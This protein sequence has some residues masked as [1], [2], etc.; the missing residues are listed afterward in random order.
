MKNSLKLTKSV[1]Y[2]KKLIKKY[3]PEFSI[4][5]GGYTSVPLGIASYM[6]GVP[7]FIHEQNSIPSYSNILLS[8]FAKKVFYTFDFSRKY[9]SDKS[10]KVGMPL[11]KKLKSRLSLK[12]EEAREILGISNEDTIILILGG[13]QGARIFGDIT[14]NLSQKMKNIKFILIRGKNVRTNFNENNVITFDYYE[15]IGVL[16]AASDLVISRAGA[17]TVSELIAFGKYAIYIPYK[18]AASNHQYYNSIWLEEKGLS[19]VIT[20]EE[21]NIR[22]LEEEIRKA[23]KLNTDKIKEVLS[24][25]AILNSE[26]KIIEEIHN[27]LGK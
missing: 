13:S 11:R 2:V 1:L 14:K 27:A 19:R 17:G 21:L 5:F 15:D 24:N 22:R 20:E 26:E 9:F 8:K 23:Q 6:S 4:V 25:M 16:Y 3:K 18:F 7:L 10:I 12:R